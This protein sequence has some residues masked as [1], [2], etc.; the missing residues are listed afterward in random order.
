MTVSDVFPY[1]FTSLVNYTRMNISVKWMF[2][3]TERDKTRV[4]RERYIYNGKGGKGKTK[5]MRN[6]EKNERKGG[7]KG[8]RVWRKEGEGKWKMK[9]LS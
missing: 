5:V 1:L 9:N 8:G 6:G 3:L 4:R 2:T 7:R